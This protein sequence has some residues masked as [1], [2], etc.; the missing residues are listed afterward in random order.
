MLELSPS[1]R[2][3]LDAVLQSAWLTGARL[4]APAPAASGNSAGAPLGRGS[5]GAS[6]GAP[7]AVLAEEGPHYRSLGSHAAL[8]RLRLAEAQPGGE[9]CAEPS[10]DSLLAAIS[11]RVAAGCSVDGSAG[12][13]WSGDSEM[14]RPADGQDAGGPFGG[15]LAR[16][17]L[18]C[19]ED[20][21]PVYRSLAHVPPP[22]QLARQPAF[23]RYE[24]AGGGN[25]EG[26]R[27]R[28]PGS[29]E[30]GGR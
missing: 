28:A 23:E 29:A 9:R 12:G 3:S 16:G 30:D 17:Q 7:S 10:G 25:A 21:E 20:D 24:P 14:A 26:A 19:D 8:S 6:G 13:E 2:L 1:K 22:P 27:P 11:A 18:I 4:P 15:L 5:A